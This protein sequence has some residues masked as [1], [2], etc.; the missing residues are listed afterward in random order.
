MIPIR[1]QL[2]IPEHELTFTTSRSPG[3]GGQNVNKVESRVTLRFDLEGSEVLDDEQ[4]ERIRERLKGRIGKDGS[5]RVSAHKHRT[6]GAN[7][8]LVRER[9]AELL[10]LA[11][12]EEAERKATRIPR[13]AKRRRLEEK[14]RNSQ[15]KQERGKRFFPNDH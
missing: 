5:L 12:E 4:K 10:R 9:F 2:S 15:R 7:R 14:K 1:D 3:P 11:L 6:Q 13:R 8:E